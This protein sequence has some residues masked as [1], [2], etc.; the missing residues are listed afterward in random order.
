MPSTL[1]DPT[2][3]GVARALTVHARRHGV[4]AEN[5]ANLET[6]GFHARDTDFRRALEAAFST[7]RAGEA[8]PDVETVREDT[9]P[10]K[11]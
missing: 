11:R 2:L 8:A 3:E 1:I 9:S 7:A 4:L 6:P 5:V 10:P